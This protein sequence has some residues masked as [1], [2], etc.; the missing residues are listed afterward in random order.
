ITENGRGFVRHYLQDFGSTLGSGGVAPSDYW[1]GFEYLAEPGETARQIVAFGFYFPK[2][3]VIDFY[4]SPSIGRMPRDNTKFNP[5]AWRPRV[6][7]QSFLRARADDKFWAA[8]RVVAMTDD[9]IRAAVK[10]GGFGDAASE[11]FLVKALGERRDAIGRA[12]LPAVN[13]I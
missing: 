7:I 5:E 10:A 9:L 1:E 11:T 3:H 13:P 4:E 2:W 6:P 8:Q 12:Y